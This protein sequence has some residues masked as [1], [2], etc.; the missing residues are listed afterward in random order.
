MKKDLEI[1]PEHLAII[2]DANRRWAKA[3]GLKPWEGHRAGADNME[4][5]IKHA[6]K[7]G[8][9]C[10]SFW[11]S[12]LDNLSKRPIQEK[13]ALLDIYE[14]YFKRLLESKEIHDNE[15]RI[16]IIGRWEEQFPENVRN[17]LKELIEKTKN[18]KKKILTFFLAYN[19]DDEMMQ[20]VSNILN[21]CKKGTEITS[22][23]I[24][25]NLMTRDLPAVDYLVR[26]GGE[27][28]LS[29]GFMM[30]DIANAQLYFT[31]TKFPDFGVEEFDR[32]LAEFQKRNRRLGS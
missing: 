17:V 23:L 28:H 7:R 1:L 13:M 24:K 4:E 29:A 6:L 21:N 3:R 9:N 32:S 10:L 11:G 5:L 20:A 14:K 18:Y 15:T 25:D 2:P 31:E 19:G 22:Q 16:N 27:P 30:W 8:I 12:S 26:T